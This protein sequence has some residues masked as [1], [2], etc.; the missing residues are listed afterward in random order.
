MVTLG[1]LCPSCSCS[2]YPIWVKSDTGHVDKNWLHWWML[3]V[4]IGTVEDFPCLKVCTNFCLCFPHLFS[5]LGEMWQKRFPHIAVEHVL[6]FMK[7]ASWKAVLLLEVWIKLCLCECEWH[8]AIYHF[9]SKA[10]GLQFCIFLRFDSKI[11]L[12]SWTIKYQVNQRL[13][14]IWL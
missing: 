5:Y 3:C 1:L 13:M 2:F 11:N 10:R 14:I 9:E 4:K 12:G 8:E 6:S 7:I